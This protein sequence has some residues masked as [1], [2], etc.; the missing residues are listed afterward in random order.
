MAAGIHVDGHT[1]LGVRY[2]PYTDTYRDGR[3]TYLTQ[4]RVYPSPYSVNGHLQGGVCADLCR[5]YPGEVA[6]A[7][8]LHPDPWFKKK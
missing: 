7:Y 8:V 2:T 4:R 1:P 6:A 5:S 3:R